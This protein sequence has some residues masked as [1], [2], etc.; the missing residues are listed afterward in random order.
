MWPAALL[1]LLAAAWIAAYEA[2]PYFADDWGYIFT[3]RSARG[4]GEGFWPLDR[5]WRWVPFHWLH[6]NGRAANYLAAFA[7]GFLP[8]WLLSAVA[9][10]AV[11]WM[12]LMVLRLGGVWRR[13]GRATLCCAAMAA[14]TLLLPWWNYLYSIDVNFNYVLA[15]ALTLT[16]VWLL[17][18]GARLSPWLLWPLAFLAGAMHEAASLPVALALVVLWRRGALRLSRRGRGAVWAFAAGC[19]AVASSP[20]VWSRLGMPL[21]ADNPLPLTLLYSAP[22]TVAALAAGL[23]ALCCRGGRRRLRSLFAD[24]LTLG[25]AVA[26]GGALLFCAVSGVTGRS[27]WFAELYTLVMLLRMGAASG[28][29]LPRVAAAVLSG[30]TALAALAVAVAP[31]AELRATAADVQAIDTLLS[32]A[33][34]G[35]HAILFR[36]LY[37][38][39]RQPLWCLG[40]ARALEDTDGNALKQMADYYGAASLTVLPAA[41]RGLDL[42]SIA[43]TLAPGRFCPLPDGSVIM[44]SLPPM[45]ASVAEGES[46]LYIPDLPEDICCTVPMMCIPLRTPGGRLLYRLAPPRYFF[47]EH[48]LL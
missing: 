7:L 23:C 9:G 2:A 44:A 46:L 26:A 19:L 47:G 16:F 15:S 21:G 25:A 35:S 14:V 20:G 10:A 43:A 27:G 4:A 12:T 34:P 30:V 41:A 42:D 6:T 48:P 40:R 32:Q 29:R 17:R 22:L 38:E 45:L 33:P 3:F 31:V 5:A 13:P 11:G 18:R 36:D 1:W 24:P 28:V 8:K 37:D 39:H